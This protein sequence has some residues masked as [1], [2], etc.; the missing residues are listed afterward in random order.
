L[1]LSQVRISV[2]NLDLDFLN[3][4]GPLKTPLMEF[5]K[6]AVG[7]TIA[8]KFDMDLDMIYGADGKATRCGAGGRGETRAP[9]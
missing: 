1:P 4:L 7:A 2:S 3:G 9:L 8:P 5:V 6:D